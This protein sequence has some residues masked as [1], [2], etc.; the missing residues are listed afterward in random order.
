MR[1]PTA[2]DMLPPTSLALGTP[3]GG[4]PPMARQSWFHGGKLDRQV[5]L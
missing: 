1:R 2:L 4:R 3:R 5:L